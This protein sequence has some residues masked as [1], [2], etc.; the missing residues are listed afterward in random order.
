MMAPL[1]VGILRLALYVPRH[2]VSQA[3]LEARDGCPGKYTQGLGQASMAVWDEARED[4]VSMALTAVDDLLRHVDPCAIGC[5]RVGTETLHDKSKSAKTHLMA[6]LAEH[7]NHRVEGV[8]HLNACYGGTDALFAA[9]AWVQSEAWDGRLA[10]V[11]ASDTAVYAPGSPAA[12]TGGAGAVAMLVGPDAA[13]ALEPAR[14]TVSGD[15]HDFYKPE[16]ERHPRV[17]GKASQRCYLAALDA[18][19]AAYD[20][21]DGGGDLADCRAW[22]FHAPYAKLVAKAYA[23]VA[24]GHDDFETRVAPGLRA[25]RAVGNLYTAALYA[26]LACW[27]PELA[28]GD[29]VACYSFGSGYVASLFTLRCRRAVPVDLS[30]LEAQRLLDSLDAVPPP[31]PNDAFIVRVDAEQRRAYHRTY[32]DVARD[33]QEGA[34]LDGVED[35]LILVDEWDTRV[36]R[37][38]KAAAHMDDGQLHRA[39]SLFLFD[40]EGRTL[41]Q[42]RSA[43]KPLFPHVWA[44][45]CCSHPRDCE[46]ERET[47]DQQGV[48]R[49]AR[50]RAA[51]EL[52]VHE[53]ADLTCWGRLHYRA[54]YPGSAPRRTEHEIDH[55]LFARY[56]GPIDRPNPDEVA[57]TRWVTQDELRAELAAHPDAYSP[58]LHALCDTG[59]GL[60]AQWTRYA[61]GERLAFD[62]LIR[63]ASS[64]AA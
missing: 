23:R 10:L 57:A 12:P 58:W 9:V 36:G 50:R 16:F 51:F 64:R 52:R 63:R 55:I 61:R 30:R 56:D 38:G 14:V 40:A 17:D 39:F 5:V 24:G 49:A 4:A 53:L 54:A 34:T 48:K 59:G 62:P 25:G 20:E 6:L 44:N 22:C 35:A 3:D 42:Q 60:F 2:A 47:R 43:H 46:A 29:R 41:L 26:G 31:P 32:L 11:V 1:H 21:G 7:G 28:P 15:T 37:A 13:L 45:A 19:K 8:T 18:C 33:P 27:C